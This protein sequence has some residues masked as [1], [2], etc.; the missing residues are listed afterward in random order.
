[1][2]GV[3]GLFLAHLSQRPYPGAIYTGNF[4]FFFF[5]FCLLVQAKS[6][7]YGN[8]IH[9]VIQVSQDKN[10]HHMIKRL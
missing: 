1:M 10:V 2:L 3:V 9:V 8:S 5:F 6:S 7:S 4:F